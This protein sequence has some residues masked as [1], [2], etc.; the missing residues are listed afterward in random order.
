MM[1]QIHLLLPGRFRRGILQSGIMGAAT[2]NAPSPLKDQENFYQQ[3]KQ[4][5]KVDSID[6]MRQAPVTAYERLPRL[7]QPPGTDLLRPTLDNIQYNTSWRG[8][9]SSVDPANFELLIGDTRHEY[10]VWES[11]IGTVRNMRRPGQLI[12]TPTGD[13]IT[14]LYTLAPKEKIDF[15]LSMYGISPDTSPDWA[16]LVNSK[17]ANW[18]R[19]VSDATERACRPLARMMDTRNLLA[20]RGFVEIQE[21]VIR[22][23]P[24]QKDIGQ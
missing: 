4:L 15:V 23:D 10:T 5:L 1:G 22:V 18:H 3:H 13:F 6:A 8:R 24:Q 16:L 19:L 12:P 11:I 17:L 20:S 21:Q 14:N 2:M 9:N 7:L